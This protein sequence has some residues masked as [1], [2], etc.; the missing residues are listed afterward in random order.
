MKSDSILGGSHNDMIFGG[1]SS[2][3]AIISAIVATDTA[4]TTT[5]TG[6]CRHGRSLLRLVD[7][8]ATT[9]LWCPFP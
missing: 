2:T 3:V 4:V 8:H 1:F 5:T 9:A 6:G 7:H